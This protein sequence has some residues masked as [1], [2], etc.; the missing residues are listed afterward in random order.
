MQ[1]Q[2]SSVQQGVA[3]MEYTRNGDPNPNYTGNNVVLYQV[4]LPD[5]CEQQV[6]NPD[7]TELNSALLRAQVLDSQTTNKK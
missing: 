5:L 3:N 4:T 7:Y 6:A 1:N 2:A